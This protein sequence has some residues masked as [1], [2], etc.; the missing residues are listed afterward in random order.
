I[1]GEGLLDLSPVVFVGGNLVV[2]RVR[3][4]TRCGQNCLETAF[5]KCSGDRGSRSDLQK[6]STGKHRIPLIPR[7]AAKR[8]T[9][10]GLRYGRAFSPQCSTRGICRK[11]KAAFAL[12]CEA[13]LTHGMPHRNKSRAGSRSSWRAEPLRSSNSKPRMSA[14]GTPS[15]FFITSS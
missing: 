13:I 12:E 14:A 3:R 2:R 4:V 10:E 7:V 15:L 9:G 11:G 8:Q 6:C 5:A 1:D